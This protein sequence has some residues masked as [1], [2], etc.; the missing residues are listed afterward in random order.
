MKPMKRCFV[1]K[2]IPTNAAQ[3]P[4]NYRGHRVIGC[5]SDACS[6]NPMVEGV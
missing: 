3:E 6:K 4:P 5:F 2:K 1:C